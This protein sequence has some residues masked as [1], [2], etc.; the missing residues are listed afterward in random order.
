MRCKVYCCSKE[1]YEGSCYLGFSVVYS[2][3]E[4][5]KQFFKYTPGGQIS[6]NVVNETIAN[7]FEVGREYFVDFTLA[8]ES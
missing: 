2:G 4:E 7:K 6:F 1:P 3:S 5:N 8:I